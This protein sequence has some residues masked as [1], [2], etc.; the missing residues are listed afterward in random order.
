A[1]REARLGRGGGLREPCYADLEDLPPD[2]EA[3]VKELLARCVV[4][5]PSRP[6]R[7]EDLEVVDDSLAG[8]V[9]ITC[10]DCG[11]PIAIDIDVEQAVLER[12][13]RR[14]REVDREVHIL[15]SAYHWSLAEIESLGE[16]RRRTLAELAAE[17][18]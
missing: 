10:S 4:G 8:P 12:I 11:E 1:A 9:G 2:P 5:A 13:A 14:A 3:A 18:R 6:P 7:R 16:R 17:D 15:A